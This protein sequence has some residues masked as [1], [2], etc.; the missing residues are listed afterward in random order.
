[1][2]VLEHIKQLA[3]GLTRRK[4]QELTGYLSGSEATPLP[5]IPKSLRGDW[6]H[7]FSSDSDL[8]ANLAEIRSE[9][10]REWHNDDFVG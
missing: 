8:D 7:A 9:W 4:K 1:M 3:V 10:Q 5:E 2:T 6:C